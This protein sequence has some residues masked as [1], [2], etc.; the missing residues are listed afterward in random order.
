MV[1]TT[2]PPTWKVNDRQIVRNSLSVVAAG[3]CRAATTGRVR[4]SGRGGDAVRRPD[5][6]DP[7][8]RVGPVPLGTTNDQRRLNDGEGPTRAR[9][10]TDDP[11]RRRSRER[12]ARVRLSSAKR[13]APRGAKAEF[14]VWAIRAVN[15]A[16][17]CGAASTLSGDPKAASHRRRGVPGHRAG[18]VALAGSGAIPRARGKRAEKRARSPKSEPQRRRARAPAAR[19]SCATPRSVFLAQIEPRREAP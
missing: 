5:M 12:E 1:T 4:A 9:T 11:G 19:K 17:E 3:L 14:G 15:V 18:R 2:K 8:L 10:T 13:S 7:R 16:A 6:A